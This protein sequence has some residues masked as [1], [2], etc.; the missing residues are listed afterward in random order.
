MWYLDTGCNNHMHGEN[1]AF[2]DLDESFCNSI[3][4]G[5]NS[6]ISIMGKGKV[7][8]QTKGNSTHTIANVL[9][10]PDLKTNFLSV[11]QLQE[12]GYEIFI[13]DGVCQIQDAKL[14]LIAQVKM[15]ANR[16]F[17]LYLHNTAHLCFLEK[18]KDEAWLWHFHYGNLNFGGL[19]TLQQKSMVTRLPQITTSSQFCEECVVSKQHRNQFPQGKS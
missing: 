14:G 16:M 19:R 11:G 15:T 8:I 1:E 2:S 10:V 3:K 17:P 18:L 6:I 5:D 7:T 12:K 9:F 13:K 4:F